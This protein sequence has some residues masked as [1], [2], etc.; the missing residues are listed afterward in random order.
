VDHAFI[1]SLYLFTNPGQ[2]PLTL[3]IFVNRPGGIVIW[4]AQVFVSYA[5]FA[6]FLAGL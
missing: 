4:P 5:Q 2:A 3:R 6:P 1:S